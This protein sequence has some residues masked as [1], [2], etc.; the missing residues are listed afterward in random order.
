MM[1]GLESTDSWMSHIARNE[2][3]FGRSVSTDEICREIRAV[4][5]DDVV[6]LAGALFRSDSMTLSLLGD[7]K[8]DLKINFTAD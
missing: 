4:T 1:L 2:I 8:S 3:Y 6:E 5:R 7:F